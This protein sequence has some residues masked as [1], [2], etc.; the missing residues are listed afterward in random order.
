MIFPLAI[1]ASLGCIISVWKLQDAPDC[2]TQAMW[3]LWF[4]CSLCI[5][6]AS[7][8]WMIVGEG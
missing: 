7:A 1:L 4:E 5:V 3:K 2:D 6:M 8:F